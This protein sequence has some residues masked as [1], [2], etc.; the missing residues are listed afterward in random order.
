MERAQAG[1]AELAQRAGA[2]HRGAVEQVEAGDPE[3]QV[4]PAGA[5]V[6]VEQLRRAD[7]AAALARLDAEVEQR[8]DVGEAH[9]EALGA[10]RRHDVRGLGDQRRPRPGEP[11]GDLGDDRPEAA[12]ACEAK[13]TEDPAGAGVQADLERLGRQRRE[14][15]GDRPLLHPDHGGRMPPVAIG[16]GD[17]A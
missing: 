12:G 13:L 17:E 9:V 6:A 3:Q 7:V 14:P 10:D 5:A 15:G 16:Q 1:A 4:G 2:G 8:R 11:V